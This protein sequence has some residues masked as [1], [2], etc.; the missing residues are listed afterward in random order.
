MSKV[1]KVG[2]LLGGDIAVL[3]FSLFLTLLLR[4]GVTLSSHL[5]P[6]SILFVVW[7]IIFYSHNLYD[8]TAAKNTLEFFTTLLRALVANFALAIAFFY[9]IPYFAITPK[10][11]LFLF[12]AVFLV[13][14]AVW[15]QLINR[16]LK[17]R[18]NLKTIV[19]GRGERAG[20]LANIL[21][22]N[23]QLGYQIVALATMRRVN[24]QPESVGEIKLVRELPPFLSAL[25]YSQVQAVVVESGVLKNPLVT[26]GLYRLL[27]QGVEVIDF[28]NFEEGL[29]RKVHLQNV[30]ELWFLKYAARGRRPIYDF[31]KR[32]L[33]IGVV[34]FFSLPALILGAFIALLIKLQDRGPIFF[35]QER[36]GQ[37]E[38]PFTLIK[39]R[40]MVV[41][42]EKEGVQ[43]T[44]E[45]DPRIT[46]WGKFLRKSRLDELPQFINILKG[47]ISFVGPRSERPQFHEILKKEIPFYEKRI[48][49][50][51]G[52]TGWAQ[53]N[54]PYGGASIEETRQK[55]A[56][57]FYYLKHRSL[58]FDLGII[59]KTIDL[60]LSYRGR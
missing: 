3:Y 17:K 45:K 8:L 13:F 38:R 44:K 25:N 50:K 1:F 31:S 7:L 23:P 34:L 22:L 54:Y 4:S 21:N 29:R 59:L 58:L 35:R 48:L 40:T 52:F 11:N 49:I 2:L 19:I 56:Y 39:F 42:A 20:E 24:P 6:F 36:I 57:D 51:P 43:W 16:T 5:A 18:F 60:V 26:S 9:F 32:L 15:R 55:L 37:N 28:E 10:R 14:F 33:D 27:E 12:L 46:P 41:D 47:D 30:D 53:I